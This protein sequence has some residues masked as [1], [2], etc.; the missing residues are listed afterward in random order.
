VRRWTVAPDGTLLNEEQ[1]AALAG[2][3][4][5]GIAFQPGDPN[6]F[7]ITTNAPV[8]IQPAPTGPAPSPR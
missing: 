1:W 8:Y 7:W 4:I 3:T 2:R 5:I 6:T